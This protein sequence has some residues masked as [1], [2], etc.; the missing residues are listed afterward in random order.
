MDNK[1][2]ALITF[3]ENL[4]NFRKEIG[5][6]QEEL[7]LQADLDRAYVGGLERGE[8]NPTI[9]SLLR[10]AKPLEVTVSELLEGVK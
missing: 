3:G 2:S 6:S 9:M 7:A 10:I 8:R 5:L 4:R 1:H